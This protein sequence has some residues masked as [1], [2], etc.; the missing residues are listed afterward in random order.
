MMNNCQFCGD[1]LLLLGRL[2][3]REQRAC[4]DCDR[5]SRHAAD[6]TLE[7]CLICG[8]R[9]CVGYCDEYDIARP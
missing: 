6:E 5:A 9:G 2:D 1:R 8:R 4:R 3:N 7:R